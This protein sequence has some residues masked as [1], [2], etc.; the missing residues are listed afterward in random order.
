MASFTV[1]G[2]FEVPSQKLVKSQY[3]TSA[4][5]KKFWLAHKVVAKERGC[6]AFAFRASKGF[7]PIY[8]G[9][10]T[11]SFEQEVFTSHKLVK[12]NQGLQSR[13]KGT[14]VLFF[15]PL[16]KSKGPINKVAIDE[17]ESYLIQAGLAANKSLLNSKKTK[18][19]SWSIRGGSG[20][21]SEA[22]NDF[23]KCLSI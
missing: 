15:V 11:K 2:P 12:Y 5:G 16:T 6:Y 8:V 10:A 20:K 1:K 13:S 22:A 21:S 4:E 9:K 14:L 19:E 23:R 7:V 3:I 17:V 18:Q